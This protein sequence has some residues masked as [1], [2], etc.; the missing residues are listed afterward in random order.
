MIPFC[1][2]TIGEE[3]INAVTKVLKSGWLTT[4][5][6]VKEFEESVK[7]YIGCKNAIAVNSCTAGL[8]MALKAVGVGKGDHVIVPTYTFAAT[9]QV[10]EWLGAVPLFVDVDSHFNIDPNSVETIYRNWASNGYPPIKAIIPV[11]FAG[12]PCDIVKITEL[13]N[14]YHSAVIVDAAHAIG[15]KYFGEMVGKQGDITVFSFYATKT[16]TTGEGG[17]IVTDNDALAKKLRPLAYF[18]VDKNAYNRYSEKGSWYYEIAQLGY[19]YNMPDILA[20][21]GVEQMKKIESFIA[22][23]REL[24]KLYRNQLKGVKGVT[25]PTDQHWARNT[26]HLFPIL[27]DNRD[28]VIAKLKREGVGASVHFIPLHKHP[29]YRD[30]FHDSTFPNADAL[31]AK[32]ISLPLY[33]TMAEDDIR[34]VVDA[35]KRIVK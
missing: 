16:I 26:Y 12:Y 27:V 35:L 24:A 13:A 22:K 29:Y 1:K 11:H 17:M 3:E 30:N 4:G 5:P 20:A 14:K 28:S 34:F 7:Q 23:R 21:I 31:Y 32:E 9:A 2:P 25:I 33:P 19:K 15:T 10:V 6:K 8:H 18:G